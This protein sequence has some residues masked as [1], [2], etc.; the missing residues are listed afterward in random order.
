L[1]NVATNTSLN[2]LVFT[3]HKMFGHSPPIVDRNL[4]LLI[5]NSAQQFVLSFENFKISENSVDYA[6]IARVASSS[7]CLRHSCTISDRPIMKNNY[8][9]KYCLT[10]SYSATLI[11]LY[12][13]DCAAS[14]S[15]KRAA[16]ERKLI[17]SPQSAY[18]SALLSEDDTLLFINRMQINEMMFMCE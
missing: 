4:E 1:S 14:T 6:H 10:S 11:Y 16:A 17:E 3:D 9:R 12:Y 8:E 15:G 13:A 2:L 5:S 7:N 18:I